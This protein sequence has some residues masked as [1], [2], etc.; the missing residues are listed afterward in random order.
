MTETPKRRTAS[1]R[2]MDPEPGRPRRKPVVR[3]APDDFDG[4]FDDQP[5][6]YAAAA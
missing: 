4:A 3:L 5:S 6:P 2:A 1:R